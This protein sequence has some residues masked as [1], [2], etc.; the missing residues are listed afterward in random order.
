MAQKEIDWEELRKKARERDYQSAVSTSKNSDSSNKIDWDALREKAKA[1]DRQQYN[2]EKAANEKYNLSNFRSSEF[3][4]RN[5]ERATNEAAAYQHAQSKSDDITTGFYEA[6]KD[7]MKEKKQAAKR[8][9]N[10]AGL[11]YLLSSLSTIGFDDSARKNQLSPL[12]NYNK[13]KTEYSSAKDI[14]NELKKNKWD[15]EQEKNAENINSNTDVLSLVDSARK[16]KIRADAAQSNIKTMEGLVLNTN[17]TSSQLNLQDY[18][19]EYQ[20]AYSEYREAADKLKKMGYDADGLIDTYTRQENLKENEAFTEEVTE[21]ADKHPVLSS[22]AYV[23]LNSAQSAALPQMIQTGIESLHND[24]YIPIDTNTGNF[25]ATNIR[26]TI[27]ETNS[28]N[29]HDSIYEKTDSELLANAS[30]FLYQTGLSIGDFASLAALPEPMSLAIMGSSAAASTAKDATD[31]GLSADKAMETAIWAGLAEIAFEKLSLENFYA[32][33]A[34]GKSGAANAIKDILKQSFTEGSEELFTDIANAIGDQIING[35]NS[36]IQ[37]QYQNLIESGYSEKEAQKQVAVNFAKQLGESF[38][39]G[40]VS[41]G[42]MGTGG[43]VINNVSTN[44]AYRAEGAAIKAAG[45]TDAVINEGLN[46]GTG[47]RAYQAAADLIASSETDYKTGDVTGRVSNKKLGR[48]QQLNVQAEDMH[49]FSQTVSRESNA[50]RL[51]NTFEKIVSGK[52]ISKKAADELMNNQQARAALSEIT[53]IDTYSGAKLSNKTLVNDISKSYQANTANT[54]AAAQAE[55]AESTRNRINN[56]LANNAPETRSFEKSFSRFISD[57]SNHEN[58][59]MLENG[60]PDAIEGISSVS[61]GK[62]LLNT[63]NGAVADARQITFSNPDTADL[64]RS[65]S[66]YSTNVAKAYVMGYTDNG[67]SGSVYDYNTGFNAVYKAQKQGYSLNEAISLAREENSSITPLQAEIAYTA[68]QNDKVKKIKADL[69]NQTAPSSITAVSKSN[70]D[71][72][73]EQKSKINSSAKAEFEKTLMADKKP[74]VTVLSK[75]KNEAQKAEIELIG[76]YSHSIGREVIVVAD[77]EELGYG[78]ANGFYKNGKIVLALNADGG[79]LSAYFG[80]ELFHDL[81]V[82]SKA[83]AQQLENFVIDFLKNSADYNYNARVAGLIENN[84]F[85]GTREQQIAQANEEIAANACF[86]VFSEQQNFEQLVKQDKSLAQKVRDFFADFIEKIKNALIDISTRNAEY[87]VLKD[88]AAAQEKIL[89]VFDECLNAAQK[90]NTNASDSVV[91][92]SFKNDEKYNNYCKIIDEIENNPDIEKKNAYVEVSNETPEMIL[93]Y[94]DAKNLPMAMMFETAY[95]ETRHDGKYVGNYHNLGAENMKKIPTLL[96]NPD[97]IVRMKNNGR[98]NAIVDLSTK[99]EKQTLVSIE[100]EQIKQVNNKFNSYNLIITAFS[101]KSN[102]IEKIKNNN[103]ILYEKNKKVELQGIDQLHKGLDDINNSTST[104]TVTQNDTTVNSYDMQDKPKFSLK[105]DSEGNKLSEQ[106]QEYFKNSKIRDENGNL[107]VVYHGTESDFTVFDSSKSRANMDI[108]G[109]FF[110]PWKIDAQGYGANVGEYYL[111]ITNP[112]PEG[113]AYKSLYLFK[114]ENNAGIKA[115]NYLIS[116]G[117]DGVNN[118]N[119]EYIAFYPEQI[120]KIDNINPTNNSDIRYSRKEPYSYEALTSKP[121]MKIIDIDD[122]QKYNPDSETRKNIVDTSINN[123]KKVGIVNENGNAVIYVDDIDTNI[124]VPKGAIKHC[125]DRRLNVNAHIALDVGN[126]LKNSIRI[127]ELQPRNDNI[128]KSYVLIGIAKNNV[129]EPYVVSFVV[130]KNTNEVSS[131]DVLYAVN[132]KKEPTGSSKSPQ[133]STAA[134]GSTI[135][136]SDLLDYVNKYYP[137]I[138][139]EDVL[140]HY[141]YDSRPQGK[142]GESALYSRKEQPIDY[143]AVLEENEELSSMN[144]DL[145]KMLEITSSQNEKLKNQF[146]ITDRHNISNN[147]VEKV[148]AQLRKQ[149]SSTYNKTSLVSRISALYDYMANAGSDIDMGYIWQNALNIAK[150]IID[151]SEQKDTTVYNEYKDLRSRIRTVAIRVPQSVQNSFPDYDSFRRENFG[152]LRLTN[153]GTE[154]DSFYSELADEYPEFFDADVPEEQQ[155]EAFVNF[156]ETTSPVYYNASESAAESMG[157]N[158]EQYANLVA[159]D[160]FE[161][162]FDVPEVK[163]VAEKHKKEIDNLKAHYRSQISEIRRSYRKRYDERLREI[164]EENR[165]K[166]KK[167]RS[168]KV[169]AL[170]RQKAHFEDVGKRGRERRRKSELRSSIRKSLNKIARLGANPTKQKH[171]PNAI[172]DSVK[173]LADAV[174]LDDTK[175]DSKLASRLND[176]RSGFE[177]I[178]DDSQYSV[179]SELYNDYIQQKTIELQDRAG[180]TPLKQLSVTDLKEIDDMIKMTVQSINNINRLF[181]KD[182]NAEIEEYAQNISK[183]LTV[184][185]RDKIYDGAVKSLAYNTMKPEYFFQYLGSETLL[186]LYHDLR[187]GEDTWAVDISEARDYALEIRKKYGW[188]SWD[189]KS[190]QQFNTSYGQI[191]LTLQER[192]GIYANSLGEHTRNH[193]EGGGFVYQQPKSEGIDKLKKRNNDNSNHKLRPEDIEIIVNSLTDKQKAYVKDMMTYLSKNMSQKGNEISKQL[194]DVE[195]FTEEVYYPAKVHREAVHQSSKEVKA[196][197][198]IKNADFTNSAVKNAKQPIVLKDFD[199]V[200]ATHVDEMSKYHAFVLPLENMDRVYNLYEVSGDYNYSSTKQAIK[201]AYG[202]KAL[203]YIDDLIKDINGGVVQEAGTDIIS[204]LTS[205]FKKNAVFASA[206]VAIQQPSAIGRALSEIDIKYFAG[207]TGTGFN[208]S[209]YIEMKKYAPVAVIKEMGYFDTNMAQSTVDFLNNREYGR[210]KEKIGAFFK[211]GSYRDEVMS[212]FAGKADEITWTH[213]WNACKAETEAKNPELSGNS[214]QLLK[215]AGERFTE[216][217]TKTQV[218]DSVFSRS[219]LMRSRDSAVKNALAFMAEPTTSINMFANAVIQANRG[220]ISKKQAGRVFASL[221]TASVLNSLLQ[222]VVTAARADDDDKDW[223]EVYIAQLL[224]NFIDNINPI[225]QIAFVKD[226]FNIFQGYDVTRADMNLFSDLY[227]AIHK[228]SSDKI[229]VAKKITGLTGAIS[230]FFGFPAKNIIR[231]VESAFNVGRDFFDNKKYS[232]DSALDLFKEEMN[233]VLGFELFNSKLESAVKGI[234][235][236]DMSAY[237][238]YAD[239]IYASDDAYDLLYSVLKK[240]GYDSS[241]YKSAKDKCIDIKKENGAKNPNLDTSMKKRAIEDYS[242]AKSKKNNYK[243]A[244]SARQLCIK[245]YGSM[246]KVNEALKKSEESE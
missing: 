151:N 214:E 129:N 194:Y 40:A 147:A 205:K 200:W 16:A 128:E 121:D 92:Y 9:K 142:I 133:L 89:A 103:D 25:G 17:N 33:K 3:N 189:E 161:K 1:K 50:D 195:L 79:M 185:K 57:N 167:L 59:I 4:Q 26:N 202:D 122:S 156:F 225:N 146:K 246:D 60:E 240:Y 140:K 145:K 199:D 88:E 229:T 183:E 44:S 15:S 165:Q 75:A 184:F 236:G 112:A 228:L 190:R 46:K 48:L 231:D 93:K 69:T 172:L 201:N 153:S 164:K 160:I 223:L 227:D 67:Y 168:D 191:D 106:Q 175:Q 197:K 104:D 90:N 6:A 216:V 82:S 163:T 116:Q 215:K 120:K 181:L 81:K 72:I 91:K 36:D 52:N 230:A 99:K 234:E 204:N 119:E 219:G 188:Q 45:G 127:N 71:T 101:A 157:L 108:Q 53:D 152:R 27:A 76:K 176:F 30:S 12:Q 49:T 31:R 74:G 166:V 64:Y 35:K 66:A 130:N 84:K 65:A 10:A 218:Y 47:S 196:D 174:T 102:Y 245:L 125:L 123:A 42:V 62:V 177:H 19:K 178:S 150:N 78:A 211:D 24:E 11:S 143:N 23:A 235:K 73:A 209:N 233:S 221:V 148:A 241:Q 22:G 115:R 86:T 162:Y 87:R 187:K 173:A 8:E 83:Q 21:F 117:Y 13:A 111:N 58:S 98:I 171:I 226:I 242:R 220:T 132:A 141:G 193:L 159:G 95:L 20:T 238:E 96:N 32:L 213:I 14:Y 239:E 179:I 28:E 169:E 56:R 37:Q 114:G 138:L 198:K 54:F 97:C 113:V 100:L 124:I 139:P 110:S 244:E 222:S 237:E 154:L 80:H 182:K 212:F 180:N 232:S 135:S 77:T 207:T 118:G 137:D 131:I 203:A 41:G 63:K 192:L 134:T 39:G 7:N 186:E 18:S 170:A 51:V 107:Q 217:I 208:R 136:I 85:Q 206:S 70:P 2:L 68:A 38:L 144:E 105:E 155:L 109:N 126:I 29:I 158:M 5:A 55:N 149:Y 243:E 94:A 43:A 61:D 34:S 210:V 224:P